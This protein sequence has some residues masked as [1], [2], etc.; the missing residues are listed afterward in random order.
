V[1]FLG[2]EATRERL[3]FAALVAA[4][5][6]TFEEGC[7]LPPRQGLEFDPAAR[8]RALEDLAAAMRVHRGAQMMQ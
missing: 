2:G 3:P 5:C 1:R 6:A 8:D 7:V 4:L